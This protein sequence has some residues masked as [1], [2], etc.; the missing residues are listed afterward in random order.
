MVAVQPVTVT[1]LSINLEAPGAHSRQTWGRPGTWVRFS[2]SSSGWTLLG[3]VTVTKAG[4]GNP[5]AIPLALPVPIAAGQ[6]YAF[7]VYS[8]RSASDDDYGVRY[9][10]YGTG[11]GSIAASDASL[12][13][14]EDGAKTGFILD[15]AAPFAPRVPSV[16]T[17]TT[18]ELLLRPC[19]ACLSAPYR[20]LS[21]PAECWRVGP[22]GCNA[23]TVIPGWHS[24]ADLNRG[25]SERS[26]RP[27]NEASLA[28][29]LS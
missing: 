16:T 28:G 5:P 6:R 17:R 19:K 8:D 20:F 7:C 9:T 22:I 24:K 21:W 18:Q 27:Y 2:G 10:F 26:L 1:E 4:A 3:S 23:V 13:I 11:V 14:L 25:L 29:G 15:P 12:Q